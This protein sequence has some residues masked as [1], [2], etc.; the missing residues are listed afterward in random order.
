MLLLL[1]MALFTI[2]IIVTDTF[3]LFVFEGHEHLLS[4]VLPGLNH[5]KRIKA[6]M[7]PKTGKDKHRDEKTINSPVHAT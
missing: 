4:I 3:L 2:L 1:L 6:A 5:K 7:V